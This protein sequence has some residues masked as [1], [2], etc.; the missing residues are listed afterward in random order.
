[1]G[2]SAWLVPTTADSQRLDTAHLSKTSYPTFDPHVTLA[3]NIP[4]SIPPGDVRVAVG[5]S[6]HDMNARYPDSQAPTE[7]KFEVKFANLETGEKYHQ[8]VYIRCKATP[9]ILSLRDTFHE[10]LGID[11][12]TPL[13]PHLSLAY[14]EDEDAAQGERE[15]FLQELKKQGRVRQTEDGASVLCA[16]DLGEW[17][18]GFEAAE[19]WI[20]KT[21]GPV[22]EWE[23]LDRIKL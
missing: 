10:N 9:E 5:K 20:V 6:P 2:I 11:V 23:V 3:T 17:V 7:G 22:K 15:R 19:V 14:I 21:T 13:F 1:M 16:P 12:K 8:S 18:D 4:A